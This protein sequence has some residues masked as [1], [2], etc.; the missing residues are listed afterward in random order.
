MSAFENKQNSNLKISVIDVV[1]VLALIA[2]I[3]GVVV[4]YKIYEKE[5]EVI[6][7]DVCSVSLMIKGASHELSESIAADDQ[8]FFDENGE[9]LGKITEVNISDAIVYHQNSQ[10][11]IVENID[12][13]L[14]DIVIKI[15]VYGDLTESGF[16]VNG[17]E[18]VAAGKELAVYTKNFSEKCLVI[19]VE[20]IQE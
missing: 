11:E 4:R 12:G 17:K 3:V 6:T 19:D 2:C 7:T 14:K 9:K 15:E 20:S 8:I 5:H 10:G 18:Y 13:E 16:L 1:I